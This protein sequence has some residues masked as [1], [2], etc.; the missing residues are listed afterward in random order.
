MS[1]AKDHSEA[2]L[3]EFGLARVAPDGH[4]LDSPSYCPIGR[5][6]VTVSF[7]EVWRAWTKPESKNISWFAVVKALLDAKAKD[8]Q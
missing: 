1:K 2:K 5:P 4:S 8:R 7:E 6:D 3:K